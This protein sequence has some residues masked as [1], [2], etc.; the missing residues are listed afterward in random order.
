MPPAKPAVKRPASFPAPEKAD[1]SG[2]PW[3][4]IAALLLAALATV[5]AVVGWFRPTEGAGKYGQADQSIAKA[6]VC[7]AQHRVSQSTSLNTNMTNPDPAN[8]AANLA[9]AANAR[10]AL[11]S[12]GAYLLHVL[13]ENPATPQDVADGTRAVAETLQTLAINYLAGQEP[14]DSVQQ[15]LRETLVRQIGELGPLCES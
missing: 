9:I 10:L 1:R 4:A 14:N 13:D 8:V 6:T 2:T 15:P 5:A 11:Y 7:D 3:V 12:G